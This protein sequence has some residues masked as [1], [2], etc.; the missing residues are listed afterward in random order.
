VKTM[1]G[2][3]P[4]IVVGGGSVLVPE[5]MPG[6]SEVIRPD[7]HD[8]A[9]A[10]GAAIASVSGE[11]DRVFHLGEGG[12]SAALDEA[13]AEACD[14]AIRAGADPSQVDV[15]ELEEIPL[16][17]LTTPAVRI[18]VKAAGPLGWL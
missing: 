13:R 3:R 14:R 18:R 7:H 10:I 16:A 4:L 17:Y 5:R 6:V 11:I 9:N 8:V 2:E 15:V 1:R 12:R